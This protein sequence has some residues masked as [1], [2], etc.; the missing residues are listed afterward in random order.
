MQH[1]KY[2]WQGSRKKMRSQIRSGKGR[3]STRT[4]GLAWEGSF[5]HPLR[6]K[7]WRVR[8]NNR[9]L[10]AALKCQLSAKFAQGEIKIVDTFNIKSHK[11]KHVVQSFR[12]LVG[13]RVG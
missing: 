3:V 6:P 4:G 10:L 13:T 1:D 7:D 2:D 12:R 11:T 9:E 5:V 8:M